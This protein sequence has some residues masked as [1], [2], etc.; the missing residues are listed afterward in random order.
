MEVRFDT[1]PLSPWCD[2][3]SISILNV[4]KNF[5]CREVSR[6]RHSYTCNMRTSIRNMH[7]TLLS[8]LCHTAPTLYFAM[9][10]YVNFFVIK[11]STI[12]LLYSISLRLLTLQ[13]IAGLTSVWAL[14]I[15]FSTIAFGCIHT[16]AT[17]VY[18]YNLLSK[19]CR[20]APQCLGKTKSQQST[21]LLFYIIVLF[22]LVHLQICPLWPV[23]LPQVSLCLY[24]WN[25]TSL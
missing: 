5:P 6:C 19:S 18:A 4:F 9:V 12:E 11:K 2:W 20:I 8:F 14:N 24:W 25:Y 1:F 23:S 3:F 21:R 17:N 15:M 16:T 13:H 10:L 22:T 7:R